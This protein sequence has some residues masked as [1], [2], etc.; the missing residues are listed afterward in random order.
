MLKIALL[1]YIEM[2]NTWFAMPM[3][4]AKKRDAVACSVSE[5]VNQHIIDTYSISSPNGR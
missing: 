4:E 5:I 3:K 2:I 1:L